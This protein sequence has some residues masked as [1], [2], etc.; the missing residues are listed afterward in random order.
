M[1]DQDEILYELYFAARK[2]WEAHLRPSEPPEWKRLG[3]LI[4]E[5]EKAETEFLKA[6]GTIPR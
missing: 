4:E 1:R 2:L 6:K 3:R 5:Y